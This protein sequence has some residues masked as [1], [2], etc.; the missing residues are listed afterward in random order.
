MET[1]NMSYIFRVFLLWHCDYMRRHTS[2]VMFFV[3][4]YVIKKGIKHNKTSWHVFWVD[5]RALP[6]PFLLSPEFSLSPFL[7]WWLLSFLSCPLYLCRPFFT[8]LLC[9][10]TKYSC[11][12]SFTVMCLSYKCPV[13]WFSL[14]SCVSPGQLISS[15]SLNAKLFTVT[16]SHVFM[17]LTLSRLLLS[18][19]VMCCLIYLVLSWFVVFWSVPF[20]LAS[21]PL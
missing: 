11:V 13:L 3:S 2:Y 16:L 14:L 18:Y 9:N 5:K 1:K 21:S 15:L 7:P 4:F 12:S 6:V 8:P 20:C 17:C 10:V 19:L